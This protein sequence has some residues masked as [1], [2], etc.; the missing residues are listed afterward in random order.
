[1][2][3]NGHEI[4][5]A[6]GLAVSHKLLVGDTCY[7]ALLPHELISALPVHGMANV[8]RSMHALSSRMPVKQ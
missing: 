6:A 4:P 7:R 3:L 1:M 5:R 8:H 2:P